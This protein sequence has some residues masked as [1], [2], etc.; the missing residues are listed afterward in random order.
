MLYFVQVFKDDRLPKRICKRCYTCLI[1]FHEFK[2]TALNA[3]AELRQHFAQM[4]GNASKDAETKLNNDIVTEIK[5]E[6]EYNQYQTENN[7]DDSD[8]SEIV[9]KDEINPY[10]LT[11]I[12]SDISEASLFEL[13]PKKQQKAELK[14][15]F[16]DKKYKSLKKLNTHKRKHRFEKFMC[17]ICSKT[18]KYHYKY[19]K[20]LASHSTDIESETC[21][22]EIN[23]NTD[24]KVQCDICSANFNSVNSLSAHK[25]K[26]V[27]KNRVLSCSICSKMFVKV[28]HLKRHELCH[29]INRP[30]KCSKCPK[31]FATEATLIEHENNH[32]GIKPHCCPICPKSFA[33][34]SAL[35]N[36]VAIHTREK[37]YLCPTCGKR[38]DSS[39]NL[40]QHMKRHLGLKLFACNL[41]PERFVS[42]GMFPK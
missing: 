30:F 16:C 7:L 28:S 35:T 11:T 23:H 8:N 4:I 12:Y 21:M 22:T 18:Y 10:D 6:R 26:H 31:S 5:L 36:H 40:N 37:P 39:T 24:E 32:N 41:C 3:A 2:A 19:V 20:H 13:Y 17:N 42:K 33:H 9:V 29:D 15:D 38:F 27:P 25:R 1:N 14:C 34:L